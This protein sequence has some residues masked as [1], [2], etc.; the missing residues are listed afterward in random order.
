MS[1]DEILEERASKSAGG[2]GSEVIGDQGTTGF[3]KKR[4]T[5]LCDIHVHVHI[6]MHMHI[7]IHIHT[8]DGDKREVMPGSRDIVRRRIA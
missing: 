3:D 5:T 6:H 1:Y 2:G 8:S 4:W 7:H